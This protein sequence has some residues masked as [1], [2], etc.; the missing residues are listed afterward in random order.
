MDIAELSMGL[1]MMELSTNVGVAVLDKS[2]EMVEDLG[3]GMVKIMEASVMPN[4]GQNID[5]SV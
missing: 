2:M 3:E 5:V 1:S 4:L